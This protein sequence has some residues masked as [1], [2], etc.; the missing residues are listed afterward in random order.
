[1]KTQIIKKAAVKKPEFT[2]GQHITFKYEVPVQNIGWG[3]E[4]GTGVIQKVN[5]V[6]VHVLDNEGNLW[7]VNNDDVLFQHGVNIENML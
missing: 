6:T 1:M 4:K 7:K 2:V 5:R 3:Y